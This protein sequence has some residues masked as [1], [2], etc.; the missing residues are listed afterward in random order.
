MRHPSLPS[1]AVEQSQDEAVPAGPLPCSV[2]GVTSPSC[3]QGSLAVIKP[4]HHCRNLFSFPST[5][6]MPVSQSGH[7]VMPATS[8][9][10]AL[11][12]CAMATQ[13]CRQVTATV[14]GTAASP[15]LPGRRGASVSRRRSLP[16]S[17]GSFPCKVLSLISLSRER[18][19]GRTRRRLCL[20]AVLDA[21]HTV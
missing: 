1:A 16:G 20:K 17:L 7:E 5:P 8:G 21:M 11:S 18:E 10:P 14:L 13:R 15:H 2:I 19:N 6:S 3:Q 9:L 12:C 4:K